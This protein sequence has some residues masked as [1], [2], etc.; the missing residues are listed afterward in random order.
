[1]YVFAKPILIVFYSRIYLVGLLL[2]DFTTFNSRCLSH[3]RILIGSTPVK[4]TYILCGVTIALGIDYVAHVF[5]ALIISTVEVFSAGLVLR[6]L[7]IHRLKLELCLID[8]G[9]ARLFWSVKGV[10]HSPVLI[11]Q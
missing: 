3:V 10:K 6:T 1:M 9:Q 11:T 7:R 5:F 8:L 2:S 4:R